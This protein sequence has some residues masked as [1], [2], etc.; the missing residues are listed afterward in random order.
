[1]LSPDDRDEAAKLAAER[2]VVPT[3]E[4]E[5]DGDAKVVVKRGVVDVFDDGDG[6]WWVKRSSSSKGG[7]SGS[8][9]GSG[10]PEKGVGRRRK[11]YR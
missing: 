8:G 5:G 3:A 9:S 2:F 10:T 11:S 1:M 6:G 4:L 7:G